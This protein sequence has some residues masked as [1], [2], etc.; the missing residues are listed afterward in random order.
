VIDLVFFFFAEEISAYHTCFFL[1][2]GVKLVVTIIYIIIS[3]VR[4]EVPHLLTESF[5]LGPRS[6]ANNISNRVEVLANGP[7]LIW[8]AHWAFL[9]PASRSR[10]RHPP[11]LF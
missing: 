11:P 8:F 7:V 6:S 4:D 5:R 2:V 1:D 9:A 3:H 10:I